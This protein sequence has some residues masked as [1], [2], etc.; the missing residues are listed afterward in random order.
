[1]HSGI[2]V[3]GGGGRQN[4]FRA[5]TILAATAIRTDIILINRRYEITAV[6]KVSPAAIF[7]ATMVLPISVLCTINK[8]NCEFYRSS[9]KYLCTNWYIDLTVI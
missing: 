4:G 8:N 7:V 5:K 2:G 1:M 3:W 9:W 6:T